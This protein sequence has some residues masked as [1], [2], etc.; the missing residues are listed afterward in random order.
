[1]KKTTAQ[2]ANKRKKM[3]NTQF[4]STQHF[5]WYNRQ[6]KKAL[7]I[8]E[9]FVDLV[10]LKDFFIPSFFEKR[11]WEKLL[12]DLPGVCEPLIREFYTS[13]TVQEDVIDC[14]VKGREFTTKV[15]DIDEVLGFG[16]VKH[17]F[18][19]FKDK[20]LSIETVQSHIGWVGEGRCLNIAT[21]PPDLRCFTYIIMFNLYP[22]KKIT[23]INNARAIFLM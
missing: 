21:Y 12:G 5:E 4:C 6:F 7:I 22:V 14:S 10:N 19:H 15:E 8:Q 18:T 17:D 11:G 20:M 3:D 13:T 16:D 23:T 9:Q 1:M 2:R